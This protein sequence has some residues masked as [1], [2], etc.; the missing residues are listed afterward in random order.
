MKQ[1]IA[2]AVLALG[3]P[4]SL[5]QAEPARY[6]LDPEH[7]AVAFLVEHIGYAKTL[8]KFLSV[9]GSFVFDETVPAVSDL[10]VA[11]VADSVFTAHERRDDHVRSGDFLA[12]DD[13]PEITFVMTGA[14][15]SGPRTGRILGD[16]TI[17]GV[18]RPVSLDVT[19]N[20]SGKYPF[21]DNYVTG[22][23]ARATVKRSDFGMTYA[24]ENELVGDEIEILI[25]AEAIRQD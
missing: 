8:G 9:E 3:L 6:V 23:S 16:L 7:V 13:H 25:E 12:A 18:T 19:W 20:K 14:E 21:N 2:A 15:P 5:A 22:I 4:A 24:L 10:E 11:I 17:R 1:L